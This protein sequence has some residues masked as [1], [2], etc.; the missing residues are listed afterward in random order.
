MNIKVF[1]HVT[2]LPGWEAITQEQLG[3]LQSSGLLECCELHVNLNYNE[4]SFD[5]LKKQWPQP[6]IQWHF[7]PNLKED[8]EHPTAILMKSIAD[9]TEE[10]FYALYMHQKG[11]TY[12]GTDRELN[13]K[14]WR[15]LLD[16]WCIE[17][18]QDCVAKLAEGY[19]TAGANYH[20]KNGRLGAHFSGTESWV[21]ASFLRKCN[22]LV[23][24][25]TINFEKQIPR[26]RLSCRYDIEAWFGY[27][28]ARAACLYHSGY[29]DH[30]S[31]P[32]P[33][34]LYRDLP[35]A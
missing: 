17:R 11:I 6:N 7:S 3:K 12:L 33:P 25:S 29:G 24:P 26:N 13:V 31:Q 19:D 28:N 10:E 1:Y 4:S 32:Y 14:H 22:P 23:L 21:T 15:W 9:S 2:D 5:Q 16:Y 34:E 20:A 27:N 8:F 18:W 35:G 30:Y